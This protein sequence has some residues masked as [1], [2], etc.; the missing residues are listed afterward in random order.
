MKYTE[1]QLEKARLYPIHNIL[2]IPYTGREK[3]VI[4]PFH[5]EHTPSC[6]IYPDGHYFCFGCGATGQNAIDFIMQVANCTFL[7]A[8]DEIDKLEKL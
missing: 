6:T 2:G 1:E 8:V 7:E 3:Q 4:C 5:N